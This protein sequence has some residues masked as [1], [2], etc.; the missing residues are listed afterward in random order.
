MGCLLLLIAALSTITLSAIDR[1]SCQIQYYGVYEPA[2]TDYIILDLFEHT[3]ADV[4]LARA[5]HSIPIAY[6]S[7]HWENYDSRF[8]KDSFDMRGSKKL[9]DWK[10]E[11]YIDW[12]LP[13]NQWLMKKRMDLAKE[14]SFWGVDIDNVDGPGSVEYFGWLLK[15]AK[16]R[17]LA[18]GLKNCADVYTKGKTI[19]VRPDCNLGKYGT[20]VD[21]FV[22]EATDSKELLVYHHFNKPVFRMYYGKGAKTPDFI[23]EVSQKDRR[24]R[25]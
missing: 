12:R 15:E 21:F 25:F 22:T 5:Q 2:G 8:D 13:T 7:A 6:F 16:S 11:R 1:P 18:V 20:E 23:Y 24:N 3:K 10:G 14:K 9:P 4:N 17:G 19:Y